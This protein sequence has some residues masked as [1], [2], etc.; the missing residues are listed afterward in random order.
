MHARAS[1]VPQN[2]AVQALSR[3][4][5]PKCKAE[6]VRVVQV[7]R[8]AGNFHV[9]VSMEDFFML[10]ETQVHAC[11]T[12]MWM[13]A[14]AREPS[15][16]SHNLQGGSAPTCLLRRAICTT[17]AEGDGC[18]IEAGAESQRARAPHFP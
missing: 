10:E 11:V 2:P 4:T 17:L 15:G 6:L 5:G 3:K 13:H 7:Q 16:M 18:C 8:V 14:G 12:R 9:S 1:D